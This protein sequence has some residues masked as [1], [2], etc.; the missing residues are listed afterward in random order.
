[1]GILAVDSIKSRTVAPVTVSDDLNV[2]GVSTVGV[3]TATS[4]VVG[5]GVTVNADGV[6]TSGIVTA[7]TFQ[8][9]VNGTT[10]TFSG[11]VSIGGTLTYEDVERV[12]ATGL[13]T[14]REGLNVGSPTGVGGTFNPQGDISAGIGSFSGA[15]SGGALSGTTGTFTGDIDIAD[16]IVHTGDTDTAIRFADT[17]TITA[18]TAGSERLRITSGGDVLIG[19]NSTSTGAPLCVQ[20][21]SNAEGIAVIGRTSDDISEIGFFENDTTTRLGEIQYRQTYMNFRHRVGDIIFCTGGTTERL[22]ITS[23]GGLT[24]TNGELVERCYIESTA[25]STGTATVNLDNGMVQY[26]SSNLA[27]SS[28]TLHLM[29]STGINT[30]MATGDM[31]SVTCITAVN[32][33]SAYVNHITIDGIAATETWVGGSAPTDGGSSGV[34]TYAFNII[35]TADATF[36][37]IANQVKTS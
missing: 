34:D 25:W 15:I 35:K 28:A 6:I 16:K 21:D 18:E 23:T 20:S 29:S 3:L 17:D 31:M 27:G 26:N 1:M 8:G 10:G 12:D 13:S 7:T 2:T 22:K 32:S 19:R 9:N 24:L 33:T 14:F 36:V 30:S 11:D 37:V 4:V 5:S